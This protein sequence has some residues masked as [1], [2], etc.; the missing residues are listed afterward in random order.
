MNPSKMNGKGVHGSQHASLGQVP[1]QVLLPGRFIVQTLLACIMCAFA[2]GRTARYVLVDAPQA[3]ELQQGNVYDSQFS[4]GLPTPVLTN[5]KQVPQTSYTSKNFDTRS[6]RVL[7]RWV[8]A[9]EGSCDEEKESDSVRNSSSWEKDDKVQYE[10]AGQHLLLDFQ[11]VDS[12][13][14]NSE[15][16]LANAML[17]L[18]NQ[19]G[20]TLLSY[21]CHTLEPTG[22]SCV[23]VLLESHVS[24]HTWPEHGVITLD[25]FTCGPNSLLPVVSV[26]EK[27]FSVA[28]EDNDNKQPQVRWAHKLR[29]FRDALDEAE[30]FALGDMSY[31]PIGLMIDYKK[32]VS[33]TSSK[34]ILAKLFNRSHS[35]LACIL[36]FRSPL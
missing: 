36:P 11:Y 20:L 21:H 2:I 16:R 18:V 4:L 25:L 19:C 17:D 26:A 10:P 6:S 30:M 22:V 7:S 3:L 32:E 29:G 12:G 27:L 13:F 8:Q 9:E 35:D 34:M 23:G 33:V 15:R 28:G 24:F 1:Y 31:F 14:L 5:G